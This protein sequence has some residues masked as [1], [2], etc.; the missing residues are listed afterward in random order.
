MTTTSGQS[1]SRLAGAARQSR[2][3][4]E[5]P[6]TYTPNH[7]AIT[8]ALARRFTPDDFDITGR[9]VA[10]HRL[11][12]E[13]VLPALVATY[14]D[15]EYKARRS[16]GVANKYRQFLLSV[17]RAWSVGAREAALR[18]YEAD[19]CAFLGQ[20]ANRATRRTLPEIEAL[21]CRYESEA[22][23]LWFA[24]RARVASGER[25]TAAMYEQLGQAM[26][27]DIAHSIE[28][29]GAYQAK[30]ADLRAAEKASAGATLKVER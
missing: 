6:N 12:T 8:A 26:A 29:F 27:L 30:A 10:V 16:D 24:M 4:T 2:S 3:N 9:A 15:D 11:A 14:G 5:P 20:L 13:D 23:A 25:E 22:N 28:L 17:Y 7:D 21:E 1:H 18:L 19:F